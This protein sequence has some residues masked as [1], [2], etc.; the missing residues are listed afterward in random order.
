MAAR[1]ELERTMFNLVSAIVT[2]E[3]FNC[4]FGTQLASALFLVPAFLFVFRSAPGSKLTIIFLQTE[5]TK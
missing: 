1:V 4:A 2:D 5:Q 3:S